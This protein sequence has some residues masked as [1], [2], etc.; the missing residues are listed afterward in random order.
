MW[1]YVS[2]RKTLTFRDK[3]D[4]KRGRTREKHPRRKKM[5]EIRKDRGRG[6]WPR[7]RKG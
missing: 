1:N 4:A 6:M 7:D 5:N 2:V 3:T